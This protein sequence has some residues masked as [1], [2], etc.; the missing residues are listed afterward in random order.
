M[1]PGPSSSCTTRRRRAALM[2]LAGIL[3]FHEKAS[4]SR[5]IGIAL[6]IVGLFLLRK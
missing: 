6:S 5:I 4:I 2:A 3:F 1:S